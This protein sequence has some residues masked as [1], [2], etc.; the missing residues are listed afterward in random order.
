AAFSAAG[1]VVNHALAHALGAVLG[2]P[3]GEA[4]AAGTP[5]HLRFNADRCQA[6]YAELA[7]CCGIAGDS[8]ASRASRFVGE[9]TDLLHSVGLPQKVEIPVDAPDHL[10][11]R[12]VDNAYESTAVVLPFN[13]RKV[14]REILA[15]LFRQVLGA[16]PETHARIS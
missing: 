14:D 15:E 8:E 4:V 13:P 1:V 7:E 6:E 9:I 10:I 12:L 11:E 3:H 16:A 5:V 2:T